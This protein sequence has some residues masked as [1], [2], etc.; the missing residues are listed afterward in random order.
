[1]PNFSIVLLCHSVSVRAG[2]VPTNAAASAN[3]VVRVVSKFPPDRFKPLHR[4][5][6]SHGTPILGMEKFIQANSAF[7]DSVPAAHCESSSTPAFGSVS[8]API[9]V[10]RRSIQENSGME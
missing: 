5:F 10:Q 9:S 4:Q 8:Q 1:M 2:L 6:Q 7:E 3:P